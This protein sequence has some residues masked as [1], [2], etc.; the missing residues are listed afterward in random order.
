[1][2]FFNNQ[3]TRSEF[4]SKLP[5]F[6]LA[7][8]D[9]CYPLGQ[10][11]MQ[12]AP[13]NYVPLSVDARVFAKVKDDLKAVYRAIIS[14]LTFYQEEGI[15][16]EALNLSSEEE[17]LFVSA[18][19]AEAVGVL[20]FDLLY[21]PEGFKVVEID[22]DPDALFLH[23]RSFNILASHFPRNFSTVYPNHSDL[24]R[25]LLDE[26]GVSRGSRGLVLLDPTTVFKEEYEVNK[27]TFEA[28]GYSLEY[29]PYSETL[30]FEDYAFIKRAYEFHRIQAEHPN[31]LEKLRAQKC[32][33]PITFRLV[34][35]KHLFMHLHEHL[36]GTLFSPEQK[37]AIARIIPKTEVYKDDTQRA[38]MLSH[39]DAVV[40][41]P[42]LG[43][44]GVDVFV[45][46]AMDQAAW[47][48]LIATRI[49]Q[50]GQWLVQELVDTATVG[51]HDQSYA[52]RRDRYFDFSP[53]LFVFK[54]ELVFGKN[55]VRYSDTKILNVAQ[56]GMFGYGIEV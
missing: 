53:H 1:M 8:N 10:S 14:L 28:Y 33:N 7:A 25:R 55:L 27:R 54:D 29:A 31:L 9:E 12:Y 38:Y 49:T 41:K 51:Y 52:E 50:D 40:V 6:E 26:I 19:Y 35:Y 13:M 23:D 45:G 22:A 4:D 48:A 39:K 16:G 44:E 56:G 20:R 47:E 15:L 5:L 34:G 21:S 30:A 17:K 3:Y 24:Y 36:S 43:A 18:R 2:F 46:N 42:I 11:K 32:C 37:E